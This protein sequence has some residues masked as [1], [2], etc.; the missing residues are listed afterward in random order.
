MELITQLLH[1][2][3]L[4]F[5]LFKQADAVAAQGVTVTI[6]EFA[7]G[8]FIEWVGAFSAFPAPTYSGIFPNQGFVSGTTVTAFLVNT[9]YNCK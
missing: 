8:V 1:Y 3:F 5:W 2:V 4:A 7:N 9:N 6:G